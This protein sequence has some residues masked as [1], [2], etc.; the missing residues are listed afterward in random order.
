MGYTT[1]FR[2]KFNL[3]KKLDEQTHKF[4]TKLAS[5]RRM[6]RDLPAEY[7][8][9]GEFYVDG[10]GFHGQDREENIL[11][12]NR[13]PYTQPSLWCQWTPTIDGMAIEWDGGEKFYE[14]VPW[15]RYIIEKVLAPRGYVLTGDVEWRGEDWDDMGVISI[16]NNKVNAYR[17]KS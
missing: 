15:I 11:D 4:L 1:E 7:G 10:G 9:E 16:S 12:Y 14:Y 13:P 6:R 3:N 17:R 8:A 2:G 5:T